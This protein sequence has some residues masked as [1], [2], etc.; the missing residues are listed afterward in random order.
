MSTADIAKLRSQ[1]GA[2]MLDCKKALDESNG[3]MEK[4]LDWLRKRGIAKAAKRADKVTAEGAVASYIHGGG[5]VG[6]LVEVNCETD[7]VAKNENFQDIV[8][9]ITLHIAASAPKYLSRNE[10]PAEAVE[11]EKDIYREQMKNEGKP[12]D[13]IEKIID[14]KL[15]KFYSEMCLLEQPFIKDED[16]TIEEMLIKKTGEIGE[17]ISIRRFARYEL[18]EGIEKSSKNFAEEVEEQ[19]S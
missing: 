9:G 12:A 13:I 19:I 2:G 11:K 14:G 6:V 4:A 8:N 18:G 5:K 17:K 16:L 15:D 7:F 3:D 1:T 10:V